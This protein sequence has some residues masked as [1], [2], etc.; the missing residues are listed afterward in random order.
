MSK[1]ELRDVGIEGVDKLH[2][3]KTDVG[4]FGD[5]KDGP[6]YD[7]IVGKE[8]FLRYVKNFDT[9]VP[10]SYTHLTLPTICSV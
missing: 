9:V 8:Y 2:W 6:L 4:A 7:W 5:T 10:V 1:I 3:I